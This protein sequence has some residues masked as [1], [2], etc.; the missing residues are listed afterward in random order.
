MQNPNVENLREQ[1][2]GRRTAIIDKTDDQLP[3][4][5]VYLFQ[6]SAKS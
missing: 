4:C 6:K 1:V 5:L 2:L 3:S